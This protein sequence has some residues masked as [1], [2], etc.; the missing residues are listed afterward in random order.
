MIELILD[1]GG[2]DVELQNITVR[3][4]PG[5]PDTI[6]L[7]FLRSDA[8][9]IKPCAGGPATFT[10]EKFTRDGLELSEQE[11]VRLFRT[12]AAENALYIDAVTYATGEHAPGLSLLAV[13]RLDG[14]DG[15]RTVLVDLT[16]S[17]L[18]VRPVTA[19]MS[20]CLSDADEVRG[21]MRSIIKSALLD[22]RCAPYVSA[23]SVATFLTDV[24][25]EN[26]AW[27]DVNYPSLERHVRAYDDVPYVLERYRDSG[28]VGFSLQR[29]PCTVRS[30]IDG[31]LADPSCEK[32]RVTVRTYSGIDVSL[33]YDECRIIE[34]SGPLNRIDRAFVDQ[35]KISVCE[36]GD[37][38]HW[39]VELA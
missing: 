1:T 30:L 20:V 11:V 21:K 22:E 24:L 18:R 15:K 13:N 6:R 28:R 35:N 7:G 38:T 36:D 8:L 12:A 29:Q 39:T 23:E 34:T 3:A 27:L 31:I 2:L 33:R 16:R 9:P 14:P 26:G 10:F 17:P 25:M 5:E 32:G 37:N 19:R 4:A